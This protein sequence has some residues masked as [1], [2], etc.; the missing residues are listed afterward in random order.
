MND[1]TVLT[2]HEQLGLNFIAHRSM[3]SRASS[4]L[5]A[6]I[7]INEFIYGAILWTT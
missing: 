3:N 4:V 1:F 2:P 6:E 7:I 5:I